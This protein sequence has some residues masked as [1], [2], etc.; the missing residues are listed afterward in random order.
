MGT[1]AGVARVTW[2]TSKIVAQKSWKNNSFKKSNRLIDC[3][4]CEPDILAFE[5]PVVIILTSD[6]L[7]FSLLPVS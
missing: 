5:S 6:L 2:A 7:T 1:I 3:L 4:R